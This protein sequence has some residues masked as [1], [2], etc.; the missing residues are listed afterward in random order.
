MTWYRA[1]TDSPG[2]GGEDGEPEP[3]RKAGQVPGSVW[4]LNGTWAC[5]YQPPLVS[6]TCSS[7]CEEKSVGRPI[8]H[9]SGTPQEETQAWIRSQPAHGVSTNCA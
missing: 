6:H 3:P 5:A 2:G 4:S 1:G 8:G 7:R 9:A